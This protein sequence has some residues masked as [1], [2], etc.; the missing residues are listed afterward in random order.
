VPTARRC[1]AEP[2]PV[3]PTGRGLNLALDA[4]RKL[5]ERIYRVSSAPFH[6]SMSR[7]RTT[8]AS[9][10]GAGRRTRS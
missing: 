6:I 1:G 5:F 10:L 8:V 9:W 2:V 7:R 3:I 4:R